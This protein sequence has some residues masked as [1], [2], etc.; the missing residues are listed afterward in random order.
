MNIGGL[1]F[2]LFVIF[3]ETGLFAGFF[4]PGDSLLFVAGIYSRDLA[5]QVIP[6]SNEFIDLIFLWIMISIAGVLGNLLG[7]GLE[8]KAALFYINEKIHFFFKKKYLIRLQIFIINMA[9]GQLLQHGL[10]LSSAHLHPL[11]QAL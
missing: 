9:D 11:L 5:S 2:L 7:I 10:F 3:A 8:K 4:L 1:W 6:S